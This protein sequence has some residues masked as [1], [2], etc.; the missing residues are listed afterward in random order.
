MGSPKVRQRTPKGTVVI[1]QPDA[2][3]AAAR[4]ARGEDAAHHTLV[5]LLECA[6]GLPE[7]AMAALY[8][9]LGAGGLEELPTSIPDILEF[10]RTQ[11]LPVVA[12][13]L[14]ARA[15]IAFI[16]AL[17]IR[18]A[19]RESDMPPSARRPIARVQ[20]RSSAPAAPPERTPKM[21][22]GGSV[23]VAKCGVWLLVE[24]DSLARAS[25]ARSLVQCRCAVRVVDSA[26][27]ASTAIASA[28]TIDA[29]VVDM[30]HPAAVRIVEALVGSCPDLVIVARACDGPLVHDALTRLGIRR[31]GVCARF[32]SAMDLLGMARRLRAPATP[33]P[34]R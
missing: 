18:L 28:E 22:T 4:G 1:R 5:S 34:R 14:G 21:A 7:P 13:R 15:A 10:A 2:A 25:V 30:Q 32:A 9:A 26:A 31:F 8:A 11:L 27:D 6:F 16:E 17:S 33:S 19:P 23:G 24:Q 29:A 3:F 12:D 20:V